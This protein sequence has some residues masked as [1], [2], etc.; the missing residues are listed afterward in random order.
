MFVPAVDALVSNYD[1]YNLLNS[2]ILEMFEF[3]RV[4]DIKSL[5]S[6]VVESF[7]PTLDKITYVQT[8]QALKVRCV[9]TALVR[10]PYTHFVCRYDQNQDRQRNS[11]ESNGMSS[12]MRQQT[13]NRFRRDD[14]QLDEDEEL[15][16]DNDEDFEEETSGGSVSSGSAEPVKAVVT[17]VVA[18]VQPEVPPKVLKSVDNSNPG[19]PQASVNG[20]GKKSM[21]LVDYN[22]SDSDEGNPSSSDP[23][24]H[25]DGIF[26][27]SENGASSDEDQLP[28]S[29][30]LKT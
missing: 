14:R 26:L 6:H 20:S 18:V 29:K 9:V 7:S 21:A 4:E 16:F 1:R 3:I 19:E 2:A 11:L 12:M 30:R 5:C 10:A 8:F 27:S 24:D 28:P 25:T 15:W 23:L 22:D 13:N 17:P